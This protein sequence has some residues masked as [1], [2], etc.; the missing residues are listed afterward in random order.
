MSLVIEGISKKYKKDNTELEILRSIDLTVNDGEFV[1]VLGP[2]GCGK[3]TLLN[4]IAGFEKPSSGRVVLDGKEVS[5]PGPDRAVVFQEN[6]LF[7]WL[8]V[9]DNV[10]FGMKVAGV[11]KNERREKALKYLKMMNLTKFKDAFISELSGG[12]KQRVSIARALCLDSNILLMDEPFSAL[13]SQT[14]DILRTETQKIWWNT[15]KTIVFITHSIEEAVL[16][17]DRVILMPASPDSEKKE[18]RIQLARPRRIDNVDV[19]YMVSSI[20]KEFKKEVEEV[21]RAEFDEGWDLEQDSILYDND[22]NMGIGL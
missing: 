7:P 16:L 12:M 17:A 21:A 15:K 1:C 11:P 18:F 14:R 10:E 3:S 8:K 2:S 19:T 9:I 22:S 20:M 13:D 4:I 5:S 6:A